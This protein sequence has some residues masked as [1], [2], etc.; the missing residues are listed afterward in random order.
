MPSA[1]KSVNFTHNCYYAI[2]I[3]IYRY[4]TLTKIGDH[5]DRIMQRIILSFSFSD[6]KLFSSAYFHVIFTQSRCCYFL[7]S[8]HFHLFFFAQQHMNI[9]SWR[10]YR[11]WQ[12]ISIITFMV[13]ISLK[14]HSTFSPCLRVNRTC[15]VSNRWN[16]LARSHQRSLWGTSAA[17]RHR[18]FRN[19]GALI[20]FPRQP[21]ESGWWLSKT[22]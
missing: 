10:N 7:C 17:S 6:P 19:N 12:A 16:G 15:L 11:F 3:Y 2:Y 22:Y 20:L 9:C 8:L 18:A 1:K 13:P 5:Y 21:C 4:D 14:G